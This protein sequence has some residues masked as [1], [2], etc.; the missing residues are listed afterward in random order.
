MNPTRIPLIAALAAACCL[1]APVPAAAQDAAAKG[2]QIATE[3]KRRDTGYKD[4]ETIAK[5]TL[6]NAQGQSSVKEMAV[7]TLE[8]PGQGEKSLI[9][10]S[11]P[12]DTRDTALL[13]YSYKTRRPTTSGSTCR[14]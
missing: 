4:F 6:R 9:I 11:A 12:A 13:S 10:F 3:V 7:K 14:A 8:V 2:L 5:M 1:A